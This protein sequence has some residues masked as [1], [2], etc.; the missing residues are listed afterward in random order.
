MAGHFRGRVARVAGV[1]LDLRLAEIIGEIHRKH[2]QRRFGGVIS[3][4]LDMIKRI[5]WIGID[6][7]VTENSMVVPGMFRPGWVRLRRVSDR[8]HKN[9]GEGSRFIGS[10]PSVLIAYR[11]SPLACEAADSQL[12]TPIARCR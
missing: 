7:Q 3:Q 5:A 6:A 9:A 2:I 4:E 11:G 8:V 12:R 10:F 1:D